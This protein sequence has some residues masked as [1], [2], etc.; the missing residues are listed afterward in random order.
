MFRTKYIPL[1]LFVAFFIKLLITRDVTLVDSSLLLILAGAAGLYE[2]K[3]NDKKLQD[4]ED[5]LEKNNKELKL[6]IEANAK[7]LEEFNTYVSGI[8]IQGLNR[9]NVSGGR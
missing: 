3:S 8:K 2:F 1:A 7:K 9:S 4:L 5:K 6:A